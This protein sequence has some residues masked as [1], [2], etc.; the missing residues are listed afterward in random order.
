MTPYPITMKLNR[1]FLSLVSSIVLLSTTNAQI[2]YNDEVAQMVRIPNSPE[3]QA[4]A[5]YGNTDVNLHAGVPNIA[6]PLYTHQGIEMDLP[7]SLTYDAS[8]IKVEQ[9][10]TWVGLAWNLNAGGRI[11]RITNGQPDDFISGGTAWSMYHPTV[12]NGLITYNQNNQVGESGLFFT[13]TTEASSYFSFLESI[14]DN[15]YETQPDFFTLNVPGLNETM[16]I[17]Y[18]DNYTPKALNNPRLKIEKTN[19]GLGNHI[20]S[21]KVISD[22]GT[23]Y[24]F[25]NVVETTESLNY[26]SGTPLEYGTSWLLT[27]IESPNRRDIYEFSYTAMGYWSNDEL[28]SAVQKSVTNINPNITNYTAPTQQYSGDSKYNINQSFLYQIRHNGSVIVQTEQGSRTDIDAP[29]NYRLNKLL[30]KSGS[31]TIKTID[32]DNNHYFN[33]DKVNPDHD[34]I[35]L[36]LDGLKI[37]G[38]DQLEYETYTFTYDRPNDVPERDSKSHDKF[39]YY[40]GKNNSVIYPKYSFGGFTFQ[41]ADRSLD[42]DKAKIGLLERIT[43]PTKGYTDFEYEPHDLYTSTSSN[44]TEYMLSMFLSGSSVTDP[45]LYRDDNGVYCDDAHLSYPPKI[46]IKKFSIPETGQYRVQFSGPTGKIKATIIQT[47]T[48]A[49]PPDCAI[50]SGEPIYDNYCEFYEY[51]SPHWNSIHVKDE[52]VTFTAG[53]YEAMLLLDENSVN[54]YGSAELSIIEEGTVTTHSNVA[55]GGIRIKS[56][57]NY[58]DLGIFAS[59]KSYVYRD[60]TKSSGRLN[61]SHSLVQFSSYVN[62]GTVNDQ[63]IRSAVLP[64]TYQPYIV[65]NTVQ[66]LSID[67]SGNFLGS[68]EYKFNASGLNGVVPSNSPPFANSYHANLQV[69]QPNNVGVFNAVSDTL[70]NTSY[71][72]ETIPDFVVRGRMVYQDPAFLNQTLYLKAHTK[73]DGTQGYVTFHYE[74]AVCEPAPCIPQ[75]PSSYVAVYNQTISN[76]NTRVMYAG[77]GYGG[78]SVV[79]TTDYQEGDNNTVHKIITKDS[80]VYDA[81]VD[82]LP[83]DIIKTDALGDEYK[84]TY[85]YPKDISGT[86]YSS[87]VTD[88]RLNDVIELETYKNNQLLNTR[89]NDMIQVG[90]AFLPSVIKTRKGDALNNTIERISFAY[91]DFLN[92][93]NL[94]ESSLTDGPKTVYIWGY[95]NRFPVAKIENASYADIPQSIIDDI[96]TKSDT[97]NNGVLGDYNAENELRTALNALRTQLPDALITTYTY[98]PAIGVTSI[99]DPAGNTMYYSYDSFN[100]LKE[101]RDENDHLITDYDYHYSNQN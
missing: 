62:N 46:M 48:T 84:T 35:R 67:V 90:D 94:K 12:K 93:A 91:H 54:N 28:G 79:K 55:Q 3:A 83:R 47:S 15:S 39:G 95:H 49:P 100:R 42:T 19:S 51:I 41:G 96:K 30:I 59:G 69:G 17:D 8:G 52:L 24:H 11:S 99:T 21:W 32:F 36:K 98:D 23:V 4:F 88:N 89:F 66:E 57:K 43:Y 80:T 87:M 53:V 22:D 72:Y 86:V 82:Y 33:D 73:P 101:V 71:T 61:Y 25:N 76:L 5:A 20:N 65:Y 85:R 38:S 45:N 97:E 81:T 10:A 77:T 16:V 60:G 58:T 92:K 68:T 31:D 40:N 37:L 34:D 2:D 27:K 75:V 56:V 26:D 9:M 63:L 64:G 29:G 78:I 13:S 14:A 1:I 74:N 6:I 70:K 7:V 18:T 44:Y 50:C